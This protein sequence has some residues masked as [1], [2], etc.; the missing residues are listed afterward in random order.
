MVVS[1]LGLLLPYLILSWR[2]RNT[3]GNE[4]KKPQHKAVLSGLRNA[5]AQL[6]RK[7]LD[8][9][10][11]TPVKHHR[12]NGALLPPRAEKAKPPSNFHSLEAS[13]TL[14][15]P[16]RAHGCSSEA[17]LPARVPLLPAGRRTPRTGVKA[18]W[19]GSQTSIP[20][21]QSWGGALLV[22]S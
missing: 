11:Y 17:H 18:G 9:N 14:V 20:T 1:F 12:K 16:R 15:G 4:E 21:G 13:Q 10:F 22:S 3:D 5:K 6:D 7:L 19:G 8:R 2:W